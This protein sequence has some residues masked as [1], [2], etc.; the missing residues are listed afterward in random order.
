MLRPSEEDRVATPQDRSFG[1]KDQAIEVAIFLLLIVP[2]LIFSFFAMR[3]GALSFV[4][5][6][7]GTILR[8]LALMGLV[9]YFV[10]RNGEGFG[11]VGWKFQ[12]AGREVA[13]G[14]ALFIP[15]F[16]GTAWLGTA[17]KDAGLSAPSTPPVALLPGRNIGEMLLACILVSVVAVAEET[18]F[19]GYLLLRFTAITARP[20]IALVLSAAIFSL[21]HGYEGAAG[22]VTVGVMGLIFGLIYLW[23]GSLIAPVVM[24]FL[25]DFLAIFLFLYGMK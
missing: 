12:E 18:I 14:L 19:R 16:L 20:A 13:L 23:R 22:V 10:W 8:D 4:L 15:F 25:Q 17:L 21:G 7:S 6:A 2:S 3:Q 1:L 24:H 5:M 11:A 9:L